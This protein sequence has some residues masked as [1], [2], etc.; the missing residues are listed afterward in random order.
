[1][2]PVLLSKNVARDGGPGHRAQHH[3]CIASGQL[4]CQHEAAAEYLVGKP[5][6]SVGSRRQLVLERVEPTG[7][8]DLT[9]VH[10]SAQIASGTKIRE[11]RE[12]FGKSPARNATVSARLVSDGGAHELL[13][14]ERVTKSSDYPCEQ[15]VPEQVP[16][17]AWPLDQPEPF[18]RLGARRA[19]PLVVG[20][21]HHPLPGRPRPIALAQTKRERARHLGA[22]Q[23]IQRAS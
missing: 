12:G 11:R 9:S 7:A 2:E 8:Q 16:G 18:F 19:R 20:V 1:M 21:G 14:P 17:R 23:G 13:V 3:V 5:M 6:R 15:L 10:Y 22:G 4:A